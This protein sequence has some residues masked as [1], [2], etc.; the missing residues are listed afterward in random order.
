MA[1]RISKE[2]WRPQGSVGGRDRDQSVS[3]PAQ[4]RGQLVACRLGNPGREF[5][6]AHGQVGGAPLMYLAARR[7][8]AG[9]NRISAG[10]PAC[11]GPA[12]AVICPNPDSACA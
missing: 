1:V 3:I 2:C 9:A 8:N 6:A 12:P 11:S 4:G 7:S 5:A 10:L